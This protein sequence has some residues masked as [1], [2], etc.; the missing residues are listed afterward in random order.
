MDVQLLHSF[1]RGYLRK[2]GG[3]IGD[4]ELHTKQCHCHQKLYEHEPN[5]HE[6]NEQQQPDY[7]GRFTFMA[8]RS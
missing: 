1:S 3:A 4:V 7:V 8:K 2:P 6:P 5:E